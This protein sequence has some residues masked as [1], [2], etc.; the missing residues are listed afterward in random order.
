MRRT[1][2]RS[3]RRAS[4]SVARLPVT[5]ETYPGT[6]GR[7]QGEVN[8]TIGQLPL[9]MVDEPNIDRVLGSVYLYVDTQGREPD[10]NDIVLTVTATP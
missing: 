2:G 8:D 9:P 6:S 10:F 1:Y 5:K 7:T 3:G 4:P